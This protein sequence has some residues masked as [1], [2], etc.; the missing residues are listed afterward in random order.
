MCFTQYS[1]CAKHHC[2]GSVVNTVSPVTGDSEADL[3]L[4]CL[5]EKGEKPCAWLW[6]RKE[7][8]AP[9]P[10]VAASYPGAYPLQES[11]PQCAPIFRYSS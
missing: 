7:R 4:K 10:A 8:P 5:G 3:G 1:S 9:D 6:G 2:L 11:D